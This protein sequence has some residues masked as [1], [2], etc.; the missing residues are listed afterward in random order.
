MMRTGLSLQLRAQSRAERGPALTQPQV[1]SGATSDS[2][3]E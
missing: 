2:D 1:Q 3:A